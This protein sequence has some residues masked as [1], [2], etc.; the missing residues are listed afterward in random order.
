MINRLRLRNDDGSALIEFVGASVILLVPLV[1]LLLS[2]FQ[3][4]RG[5]F[6]AS[7][8]AREAGRAFA[9][10]PSTAT[11]IARADD[12]ARLAFEDQGITVPPVVRFVEFGASCAGSTPTVTP[13]LA[14]GARFTVC[15]GKQV[16]LPYADRG[17]FAGALHARV[18]VVGTYALVVDTYREAS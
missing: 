8:A 15:V 2:V 1:Y 12:A 18:E 11:G 7:Q 16:P 3:V 14:P 6:A 4:Q 9:T 5:S 10:A 13:S 17:P